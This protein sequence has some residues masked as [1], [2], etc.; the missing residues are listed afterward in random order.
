MRAYGAGINYYTES[1]QGIITE[2]PGLP[3]P[4]P[5]CFRRC[6][7]APDPPAPLSPA[8][9]HSPAFVP[10]PA[11]PRV[12]PRTALSPNLSHVPVHDTLYRR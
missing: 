8:E 2:R 3:L 6:R 1:A 5:G 4:A 7:P 10:H 11:T 9:K 12:P